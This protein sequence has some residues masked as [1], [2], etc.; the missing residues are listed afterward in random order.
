MLR[1]FFDSS[2]LTKYYHDEIGCPRVHGILDGAD[3]EHFIVVCDDQEL[4]LVAG[5]EGL[6]IINPGYPG[7]GPRSRGMRRNTH[8]DSPHSAS[9]RRFNS[10]SASWAARMASRLVPTYFSTIAAAISKATTF[11]T[12]TLAAGTAQTSDRS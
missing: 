2:A 8:T 6:T 7:R 9:R 3:S 11:S 4:C 10:C 5:I 1:Y 12:I